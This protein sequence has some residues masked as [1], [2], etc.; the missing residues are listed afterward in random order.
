[1]KQF[2]YWGEVVHIGSDS[3]HRVDEA[4]ALVPTDMN[5]HPVGKAFQEAEISLVSLSD[6]MYIRIPFQSSF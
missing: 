1:M 6:L 3:L 5:F 4:R 2:C